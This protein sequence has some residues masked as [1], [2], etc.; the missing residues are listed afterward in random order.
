MIAVCS[1]T[2]PCWPLDTGTRPTTVYYFQG[3]VRVHGGH[4]SATAL[5]QLRCACICRFKWGVALAYVMHIQFLGG[6][7]SKICECACR[8]LESLFGQDVPS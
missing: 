5:A 2:L 4:C 1:F 7:L 8:F 6:G 3:C